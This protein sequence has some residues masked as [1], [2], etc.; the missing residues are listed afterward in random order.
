MNFENDLSLFEEQ[1]DARYSL[2]R[3]KNYILHSFKFHY[4]SIFVIKKPNEY[5]FPNVCLNKH[6]T[7]IMMKGIMKLLSYYPCLR[8]FL[9]NPTLDMEHMV[10]FQNIADILISKYPRLETENILFYRL[11]FAN[12]TSSLLTVNSTIL[13][14][15]GLVIFG[16]LALILALYYLA[17]VSQSSSGYGSGYQ[18]YSRGFRSDEAGIFELY[19]KSKPSVSDTI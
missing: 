13:A 3:A 19:L 15:A 10:L 14:V 6:L 18:Y 9:I 16:G 7:S 8:E 11:F 17:N 5:K 1:G 4:K 12:Y 2:K